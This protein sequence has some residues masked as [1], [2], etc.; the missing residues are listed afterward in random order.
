MLEPRLGYAICS[1]A[2]AGTVFLSRLLASTGR[3]GRPWEFFHDPKRTRDL[4]RD[5]ERRLAA[6][7]AAAATP[8]GV[9]G[10]KVFSAHF[11]AVAAAR[12]AERLPD[13]RLVHVSRRDL[14]GQALSFARAL[15]TG[16][17]KASEPVA[18][19]PRYD[20]ALIA[21]CLARLA[22]GQAR[23]ECW[24]ARNGLAP[25][26]LVYEEVAAQPQAS[27]DAVARH[28]GVAE[29]VPIDW[30]AVELRVQRDDLSEAW[31]RRFLAE[32]ADPGY[33]DAGRLFS[34]LRR[35][36]A[37]ARFFLGPR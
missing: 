26:R 12:W 3:L 24:F 4:L 20:A 36:G 1:E 30:A 6:L 27:V 23:W 37:F 28:L 13:L 32:R 9:Y 14:L 29:P 33:L 15:Q 35:G 22:Y 25:L 10:L 17:Y 16:Q 18:G 31:R 19:E 7:A 34:R 2:R 11:D 21:D 8:N 5:P